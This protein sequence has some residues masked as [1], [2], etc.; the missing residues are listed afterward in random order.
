MN[1]ISSLCLFNSRLMKF[2]DL[3]Q[4]TEDNM[5]LVPE[6]EGQAS[7]LLWIHGIVIALIGGNKNKRHTVEPL[8]KDTPEIRTPP[9]IR[10]LC[11]APAT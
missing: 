10:T 8:Y 7:A 3:R 4:I 6:S 11:M 1:K 2:V 5:S 9:L